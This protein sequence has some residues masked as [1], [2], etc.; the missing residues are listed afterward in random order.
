[1]RA[2]ASLL[3]Q[4]LG[5]CLAPRSSLTYPLLRAMATCPRGRG[6]DAPS[7]GGAVT[8]WGTV[9][10]L[11]RA[12]NR[13]DAK[14]RANRASDFSPNSEIYE[15][16]FGFRFLGDPPSNFG[17]ISP[18][19]IVDVVRIL[20]A[21]TCF[22]QQL[23]L[24]RR[25]VVFPCRSTSRNPGKASIVHI[26][27]RYAPLEIGDALPRF[28]GSKVTESKSTSNEQLRERKAKGA[29]AVRERSVTAMKGQS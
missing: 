1:M 14:S 8:V 12:R 11:E 25:N 23:F 20:S 21:D 22:L 24:E 10:S 7:C 26:I 17:P 6:E 27:W 9:P 13:R 3:D 4:T 2:R 5:N 28:L 29:V 18:T 15:A 19:H 16:D